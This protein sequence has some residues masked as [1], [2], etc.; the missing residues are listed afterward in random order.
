[1]QTE[2][3]KQKPAASSWRRVGKVGVALVN[4]L[5]D[6]GVIYRSGVRPILNNL[7]RARAMIRAR[8][9]VKRE[10]LT[11]AQAVA[12]AGVPIEQLGVSLDIENYCTLRLFSVHPGCGNR[13]RLR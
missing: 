2:H 1:M 12:A 3:D 7:A 13:D 4:P 8:Q 11:W 6:L 5:S 10:P 9:Q